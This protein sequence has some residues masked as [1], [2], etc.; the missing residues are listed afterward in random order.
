[1]L[2]MCTMNAQS[3]NEALHQRKLEGIS[4]EFSWE[5]TMVTCQSRITSNDREL[6]NPIRK[7]AALEGFIRLGSRKAISDTASSRMCCARL[8]ATIT[9]IRCEPV[10]EK[11]DPTKYMLRAGRGRSS[12]TWR[13]WVAQLAPAGVRGSCSHQLPTLQS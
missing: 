12:A 3:L 6:K 4:P 2:H 8:M 9:A 7:R 13:V 5:T 1:M 10:L 11:S